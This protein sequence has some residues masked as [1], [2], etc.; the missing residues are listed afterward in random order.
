MVLRRVV[1]VGRQTEERW[2]HLVVEEVALVEGT[3]FVTLQSIGQSG[4]KIDTLEVT[5]A[6]HAHGV[7]RFNRWPPS[8]YHGHRCL[9]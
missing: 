2:T 7:S 4:P 1:S 5:L 8:P 9:N 3:N 6:P